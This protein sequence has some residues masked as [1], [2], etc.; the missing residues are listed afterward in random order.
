MAHSDVL[1]C[2]ILEKAD[3]EV[4]ISVTL[5]VE[6][7]SVCYHILLGIHEVGISVRLQMR[8][9]KPG[10]IPENYGANLKFL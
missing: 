3:C 2:T 9:K 4:L 10:S 5:L 8:L 6:T 7:F 1:S